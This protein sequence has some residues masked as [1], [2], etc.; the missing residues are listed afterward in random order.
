MITKVKGFRKGCERRGGSHHKGAKGVKGFFLF[1]ELFWINNR[2]KYKEWWNPF[3]PFQSGITITPNPFGT[4]SKPFHRTNLRFD[5]RAE[6]IL[7]IIMTHTD[8]SARSTCADVSWVKWK[9]LTSAYPN[10]A[11]ICWRRSE[12]IAYQKLS[13]F[14]KQIRQNTPI[15][16]SIPQ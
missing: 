7:S 8:T 10:T 3:H 11:H 9:Y 12:I 1:K 15:Y 2:N 13:P 16:I 14:V 5:N 6:R 4:V